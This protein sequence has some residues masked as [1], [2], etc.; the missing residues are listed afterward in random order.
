MKHSEP[1]ES[2]RKPTARFGSVELGSVEEGYRHLCM[3]CY[4][5]AISEH[6]GVEFLHPEFQ[7]VR[8]AD[9]DDEVHEFHFATRLLGDRVAIDAYEVKE[10]EADGYEFQMIGF[11]PEGEILELYRD[12]FDKMRRAMA[13][14]HLTVGEF[15]LAIADHQTVRARIDCDIDGDE[16]GERRPRLVIDGKPIDWDHFGRMLMV[17]EGWQFKMEVYDKSEER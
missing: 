15:G 14:K 16:Y 1:C 12:L 13:Q 5:A 6:C 11:D 9:V 2:C 10:G 3:T 8:L 17:F 4:N 7:P